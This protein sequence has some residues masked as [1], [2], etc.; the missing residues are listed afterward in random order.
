MLN[1]SRL[2]ALPARRRRTTALH[3]TLL[4]SAARC[5]RQWH[6]TLAASNCGGIAAAPAARRAD[7]CL[8]TSSSSAQAL[9]SHSCPTAAVLVDT[10]DSALVTLPYCL[11]VVQEKVRAHLRSLLVQRLLAPLLTESLADLFGEPDSEG[12]SDTHPYRSGDAAAMTS[13]VVHSV[14]QAP[15]ALRYLAF[16]HQHPQLR[17]P[18]WTPLWAA[19][20]SSNTPL[21][22]A[23]CTPHA[24]PYAEIRTDAKRPD[25]AAVDAFDVHVTLVEQEAAEALVRPCLGEVAPLLGCRACG[26]FRAVTTAA[27]N[28]ISAAFSP[29]TKVGAPSAQPAALS[30]SLPPSLPV[31]TYWECCRVD[32]YIPSYVQVQ[33]AVRHLLLRRR[34]TADYT[35]TAWSAVASA[36]M[37]AP[38]LPP[39]RPLA[40]V[41]VVVPDHLT[42]LYSEFAD[43]L[44]REGG[45]MMQQQQRRGATCGGPVHLLLFNS[46]GLAREYAAV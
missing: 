6:S 1:F 12:S 41:A 43:M 8:A 9:S 15:S 31:V 13:A 16:S 38:R 18:S 27:H 46:K 32:S 36:F 26:S 2:G 44:E 5:H 45:H 34:P 22:A 35:A 20:P 19:S 10:S 3:E 23:P 7:P 42:A 28:V 21:S 11:A 39:A 29:S 33:A 4:A 40:L 37:S 30:P 24:D 17:H 14:T 25:E